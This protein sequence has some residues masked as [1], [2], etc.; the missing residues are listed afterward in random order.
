[1]EAFDTYV[2]EKLLAKTQNFYPQANG[3]WDA[4]IGTYNM[5]VAIYLEDVELFNK[6]LTQFYLGNAQGGNTASMGSML[7]YIYESGEAQESSR[8]QNHVEMGLTGLAHQCNIA[9]NQG[10]D[11][12]E[13]YDGRLLKGVVYHALYNMGEDVDSVTFISDKKRGETHTVFEIVYQHYKH[14]GNG[15]SQED[16]DI[17]QKM[18]ENEFRGEGRQIKNEVGENWNWYLAMLFS[19]EGREAVVWEEGI[20][21]KQ[22]PVKKLYTQGEELDL[23]GIQIILTNNKGVT[24]VIDPSDCEISGF[25]PETIGA[26][27]VV[28]R[29]T[30]SDGKVL[31]TTFTV[32]VLK[33]QFYTRQI[34]V[35]KKPTK[36]SYYVG[37]EFDPVGM[38]VTA[39][40]KATVSNATREVPLK[41]EDLNFEYDFGKA[42]DKAE[43]K[44]IYEEEDDEGELQTFTAT[45]KVKVEEEPEEEKYYV[46][47]IKITSKPKK[48]IYQPGE[49]FDPEG[50]KVT[51][52]LDPLSGEG[53]S[54][55]QLLDLD[56]L[57]FDYD[58]SQPGKKTVKIRY[59]GLDKNQ[60]GKMFTVTLEVT[61][62]EPAQEGFYTEKIA[63]TTKPDKMTY[64]VGD[65]FDPTGMVVTAYQVNMETGETEEEE[66]ENYQIAPK[67]LM[68]EGTCTITVSYASTDKDGEAK[69]FKDTLEVQVEKAGTK[70]DDPSKPDIPWITIPVPEIGRDDLTPEQEEEARKQIGDQTKA[71]EEAVNKAIRDKDFV[72]RNTTGLDD[73]VSKD[74]D[75]ELRQTVEDVETEAVVTV[76]EDGTVTTTVL[77]KKL[78]YDVSLY[79][80][81]TDEKVELTGNTKK[82]HFPIVL[83]NEGID[84]KANYVKATHKGDVTYSDMKQEGQVRY[85]MIETTSFSPFVLE[86]APSKPAAGLRNSRG[87][88]AASAKKTDTSKWVQDSVGWWYKKAD[89]TWPADCWI[90][91]AWNGTTQW[92]R[93]NKEG[94][95]V[96][97]WYQDTDG[98]RYYLH[99]VS[100]GSQGYMYTGWH[101]ISGNWYY[102]RENGEGPLGS[103]LV[104]GTTPDG[105]TTD[106]QGVWIK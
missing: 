61:V 37:E 79:D 19:R 65:A 6:C 57:D 89:G 69:M 8:D 60:E 67:T 39:E 29:Y 11:M 75:V 62:A 38:E 26:Q 100:D 83:P 16:L 96:T 18:V 35:T 42:D 93:F 23:T 102:F 34:N 66:I 74:R 28:I 47:R 76:G 80:V 70:P 12:F 87:R 86:F 53:G 33:E 71:I 90:Q 68:T 54:K 7:S 55:E 91:L 14:Y 5:A 13:A 104:N 64:Q 56:S 4:L 24:T 78:V 27:T 51:A 1:M 21:L 58:F 17:L 59:A 48:L 2:R 10:L 45:V 44:V 84:P 88:S 25:D 85:T 3:N 20:S 106:A 81:E 9:W 40:Q 36:T 99:D 72:N 46:S 22:E 50:L 73:V 98:S 105:Y 82:I 15:I 41:T 101:E 103:L 43:V 49:D 77:I 52:V 31:E 63:I 95:M 92:Y 32:E 94:Y 97:G 30:N